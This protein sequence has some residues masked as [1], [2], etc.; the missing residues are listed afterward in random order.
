MVWHRINATVR[1][2]GETFQFPTTTRSSTASWRVSACTGWRRSRRHRPGAD[3]CRR[4][5]AT[6]ASGDGL[7]H[8]RPA[9]LQFRGG[10]LRG[11][12]P[13]FVIIDLGGVP[14]SFRAGAEPTDPRLLSHPARLRPASRLLPAVVTPASRRRVRCRGSMGR[15]LAKVLS[16]G[17]WSGRS[18]PRHS[19]VRRHR[20]RADG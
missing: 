3:S 7:V 16:L 1:R 11:R 15:S 5:Q 20:C 4:R 19:T 18:D 8:L 17:R 9:P 14:V 12:R 13:Q 10:R 2:W 6:P